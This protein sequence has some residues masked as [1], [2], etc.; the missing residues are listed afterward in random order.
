MNAVGEGVCHERPVPGV[1]EDN[2]GEFRIGRIDIAVTVGVFVQRHR[3]A[4]LAGYGNDQD[5]V[6]GDIV[7]IA[8]AFVRRGVEIEIRRDD[9]AVDRRARIGRARM[10]D[11]GDRRL[12]D[13]HVGVAD[14]AAV[15]RERIG[16]PGDAVRIEIAVHDGVFEGQ[17]VVAVRARNISRDLWIPADAD[18]E[19]RRAVCRVDMHDL[20]EGYIDRDGVADPV[21]PVGNVD[22]DD[23]RNALHG[24]G[25]C[26]DIAVRIAVIGG[27]GDRAVADGRRLGPV[28]VLNGAQR[29]A[30]VRH[31]RRSGQRQRS[32]R[33]VI[34][35]R[36][37][38]P[39]RCRCACIRQFQN[40]IRPVGYVRE[41]D[42]Q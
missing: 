11:V 2:A 30:V 16:V 6:A 28:V 41:N 5:V 3:R 10:G 23:V 36:D 17:G 21:K 8:L 39:R 34:V 1:V 18:D 37:P 25:H 29:R 33:R 42:C 14:D 9:D 20:V 19:A 12:G 32:G 31:A 40:L 22:R 24:H 35:D 4:R 15:Q 7:R 26:P 27:D 38:R 13:R